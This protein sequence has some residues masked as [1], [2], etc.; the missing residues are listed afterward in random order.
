MARFI[1]YAV[2]AWLIFRWMDMIFGR[3][4]RSNSMPHRSEPP[5][6][7]KKKNPNSDNIGDYVDFEEVD[8]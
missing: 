1:F 8:D 7:N 6:H 3:K 5:N 2:V 4:S